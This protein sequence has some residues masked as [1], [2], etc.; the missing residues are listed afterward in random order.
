MT[1][2]R[3]DAAGR[4]RPTRTAHFRNVHL[5]QWSGY[6][7]TGKTWEHMTKARLS[8]LILLLVAC[9]RLSEGRCGADCARLRLSTRRAATASISRAWR[10][11]RLD[12]RFR[13]HTCKYGAELDDQRF[14][15]IADGA[16]KASSR[17]RLAATA[18]DPAPSWLFTR[19]RR[20]PHS[21]GRSPGV[22]SAQTLGG[23]CV[24]PSQMPRARSQARG[25]HLTSLPATRCGFGAL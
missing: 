12:D 3:A 14:E 9:N 18:L 2:R 16:I 5:N 23:T 19:A 10:D 8:T 1:D 20:R 21:A 7:F 22:V 17:S 15:P 4:R 11:A 25:T 6:Y 13:A 24:S